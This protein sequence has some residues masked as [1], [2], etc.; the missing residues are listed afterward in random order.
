[1]RIGIALA[2]IVLLPREAVSDSFDFQFLLEQCEAGAP[3]CT[4]YVAG[5]LTMMAVNSNLPNNEA[6]SVCYDRAPSFKA[7]IQVVVNYGEGH[8]ETW[9]REMVFPVMSA[10]RQTW[11]CLSK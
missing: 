8:P 3:L 6:F 9:S 1:M 7:A 10:L 11:P 2:M 5:I 4:G